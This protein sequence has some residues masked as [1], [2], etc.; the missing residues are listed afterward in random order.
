MAGNPRNG[1]P[2]RTLC[3][4]QRSLGLPCWKCGKEIDYSI[5]GL[6]AQRS[7]WAFTLDHYIPLS[8]GG[9]LLDRA[10]ARSAHRKCNSERGNR[11]TV[12]LVGAS[13]RW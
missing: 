9:A 3:A 10:N 5:K 6:A 7:K 1:R 12:K 13:R 4:W 2:Y 11:M 8:L